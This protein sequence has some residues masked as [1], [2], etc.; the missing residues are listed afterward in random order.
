MNAMILDVRND[1]N[2]FSILW[3]W[4]SKTLLIRT[5]LV[6]TSFL[7]LTTIQKENNFFKLLQSFVPIYNTLSS[8]QLVLLGFG[9]KISRVSWIK[10]NQSQ[11]S[12]WFIHSTIGLFLKWNIFDPELLWV[13][14]VL[15]HWVLNYYL[16]N[17]LLCSSL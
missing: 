16:Q 13:N 1:K 5:L 9:H 4:Y 8:T 10:P 15:L 7:S 6:R 14:K 11:R 17:V 2:Q 3:L 12:S